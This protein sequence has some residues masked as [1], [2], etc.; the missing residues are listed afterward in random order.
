MND[1]LKAKLAEVVEVKIDDT[2]AAYMAGYLEGMLKSGEIK[3][4][5]DEERQHEREVCGD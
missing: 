1:K 5:K 3:S 4:K 2:K